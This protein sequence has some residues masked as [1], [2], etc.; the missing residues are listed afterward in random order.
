L[1]TSAEFLIARIQLTNL[2]LP[3][4]L[5]TELSVKKSGFRVLNWDGK[6]LIVQNRN[7]N[8]LTVYTLK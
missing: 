4:R 6:E 7:T 5:N 3:E 1:E 8:I 2:L